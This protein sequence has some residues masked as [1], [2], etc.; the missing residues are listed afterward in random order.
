[1]AKLCMGC[2]NP[3]PEGDEVCRICGRAKDATNPEG[4]LPS[5]GVLHEHYIVGRVMSQGSD[6]IL[7]LAYDRQVKD[8]CFIQEFFPSTLCQRT[9]DGM[10]APL[11]GC[12]NPFAELSQQFVATMRKVARLRELPT[13]LSV[14]D[15]FEENGTA[16]VVSEYC[17]GM[18]LTKKIAQS[19]GRIP[20]N[21]ARPLF[22][23][24]AGCVV[25]LHNVGIYHLG[26]CPDNILIDQSGKPRLRSFTL[27]AARQAGS[28]LPPQL[29][30]GYAAP[31]QYRTDAVCD[32]TAD[33]YGLAATLFRTVTGNEPPAGNNRSEDSDDLFM[34]AEI[35][36]EL[37]QP[38]CVALFNALQV[39]PENRTATAAELRNQ[40]STEPGVAAL[41]DEVQEE[42]EKSAPRKRAPWKLIVIFGACLVALGVVLLVLLSGLG[43]GSDDD[44]SKPSLLPT[45]PTASTTA[46][47]T[48]SKQASVDNVVGQNLYDLRET[49]LG[50]DM[51]LE[52]DHEE[53]SE[54]PA[55]TILSQ[56]PEAGK[57]VDKETV[58]KVVISNG[59]KDEK[60]K[61][62]DITGWQ[63]DHAEKYL[64]ALGFRV[65][66]VDLLD[67]EYPAGTVDSTDPE[68]GTQKLRGDIIT[69]RI[70]RVESSANLEGGET[71]EGTEGTEGD[72]TADTDNGGFLGGL[73]G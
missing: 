1:M 67:S 39:S 2:M 19:G 7:Y 72:Q 53:Y 56:S 3:L 66:K 35:A 52:L 48:D 33:V 20:W 69:L 25:H 49:L 11:G 5:A 14:Y 46:G 64:I 17:P 23:A 63:E 40:L 15:I 29:A 70:S 26:I 30:V 68:I 47:K 34:S 65:E 8:A 24:L 45:L 9:E 62:P 54:K 31:E 27:P 51:R 42:G 55:G 41:V 71:L 37:T 36:E 50:G 61:V 32:E 4:C 57:V 28:D 60:L 59:R 38:V 43:G 22:T 6:S 12:E 58:I 21:E 13:L 73:F 44:T 10:V 16:Y 18:T